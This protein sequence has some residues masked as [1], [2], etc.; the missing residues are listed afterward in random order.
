MTG[1]FNAKRL[2]IWHA[3][4]PT[5]AAMIGIITDMLPWISQIRYYH[6][7]HQHAAGLTPTTGVGDPPLDIT[8]TPDAHATMAETDLDSATLDLAPITT[9]IEVVATMTLPEVTP[10]LSTD[11]PIAASHVTGALV[12][13]AAAMTHLTADLHLIGILPEMTADRNTDSES[14]TTD[15]PKDLHPLH[16]HHLGNIR[17]RDTN[18][19]QLMTHHQSTTAQMTM[20]AT[21]MM[22]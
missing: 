10:D 6:L 4:A 8:V 15:Q 7:V 12:P 18:R 13:T 16:R 17:T 19:S 22:I 11:L 1:V 14:N 20:K 5:Y 21:Q 2:V 3:I 9:A